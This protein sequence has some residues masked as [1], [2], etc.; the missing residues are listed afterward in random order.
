MDADGNFVVVSTD[1]RTLNNSFQDVVGQRFNAAG[2]AEGDELL[3]N[4]ETVGTQKYPSV[5]MDA[6]GNFVVAWQT[7]GQ[8]YGDFGIFARRYSA[9]GVPQS[10]EFLVNDTTERNQLGAAVAMSPDGDFIIAWES[11]RGDGTLDVFA[12]RYDRS[13]AALGS[14]FRVN[15]ATTGGS[16]PDVAVESDGDF[17]IAWGGSD[18]SASG[19]LAERYNSTGARQGDEFQ[20]N[21][22]TRSYQSGPSVAVDDDGDFV[23]V[24]KSENL[25]QDGDDAGVF[26]QRYDRSGVPQG[27]EFQVNSFTTG[28]QW[29]PDVAMDADGDFVVAWESNG[30][31]VSFY[32]VFA[33]RFQG[34]GPVAGDFTV[35]GRADILWRNT[36]T[37]NAILWQM[38]GFDKQATGS[39]GGAGTE[40]QVRGLA[41]FNADTKTDLLWRNTVTGQAVVWLMDGFAKL[42]GGA[43][44][45]AS[46]D[47]QV[48]STGDFDGDDH[49]DVLWRNITNGTTLIWKMDGLSKTA[50][51]GIGVVPLVWE[52]VGVGDFDADARSDILW[53]HTGTGATVGWRMDGFSKLAIAGLGAVPLD[54]QV[55]GLGTFNSDARSDI[56]W[57]NTSTGATAIWKMNGLVKEDS[58]TIGKPPLVWR[59]DGVGDTN[60]D[61]QS[62][63]VWRHTGN[64]QS[65]VWQMDGFVKDAVGGIGGVPLVWEVQ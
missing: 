39:I 25:L 65:L 43:I 10:G 47:W 52:V 38:D 11:Y 13:G 63:I 15:T 18:G 31:D 29:F 58:A 37:G 19:I 48:V 28:D 55:A 24:W 4:V 5:A 40:W 2:G 34:D 20:V 51:G 1:F 49:A 14:E 9:S 32:E 23:V 42:G 46:L 36:D 54:W 62:D 3:I 26:G 41:D 8:D 16:S 56:L 64:G 22:E 50:S 7:L 53:R 61:R 17:I 30:R 33:Q 45:G 44:G 35:D 6:D 60:G 27:G 12:K 59:I 57:R 21:T